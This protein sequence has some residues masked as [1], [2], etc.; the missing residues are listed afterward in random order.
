MIQKVIDDAKAL[1]SDAVRSEAEGQSAYEAF[2]RDTTDSIDQKTKDLVSKSVQKARAE[3]D[4]VTAEAERDETLSELDQLAQVNA[5]LH[6]SCD[7]LMKNFET[8]TTG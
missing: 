5:D 2:V 8:R 3:K 4:L 1:E 7:F 6:R